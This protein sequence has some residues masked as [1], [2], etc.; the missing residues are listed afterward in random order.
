[1]TDFK[2]HNNGVNPGY[3]KASGHSEYE[4]LKSNYKMFIRSTAK[5]DF[6]NSKTY[7]EKQL[8][9][10]QEMKQQAF[11][12]NLGGEIEE[13][14][15]EE[16]E[17]LKKL[18]EIKPKP[19]P[20]V[21]IYYPPII[22]KKAH[23]E[24]A[25]I[26]EESTGMPEN[27]G[28]EAVETTQDFS[29]IN[30]DTEETAETPEINIQTG[31]ST[32]GTEKLQLSEAIKL[33]KNAGIS[34]NAAKIIKT[35]LLKSNEAGDEDTLSKK[36]INDIIELK[37]T[38]TL[39]GMVEQSEKNHQLNNTEKNGSKIK[40]SNSSGDFVLQNGTVIE[41]NNEESYKDII[42]QYHEMVSEKEDNLLCDVVNK[43]SSGGEIN[44][45][46]MRVIRA[47]RTSGIKCDNLM[48]LTD[49]CLDENS[50]I[51]SENLRAITE[52]KKSGALSKDIGIMLKSCLGEDGK[53]DEAKLRDACE[54]TRGVING[55]NIAD[56][57]NKV[58]DDQDTKDFFY[59]LSGFF[60]HTADMSEVLKTITDE[61]GNID[62][63][64]KEI[65]Y[66]AAQN[67]AEGSKKTKF[68]TFNKQIKEIIESSKNH[69]EK[70]SN[71]IGWS[72]CK[73]MSDHQKNAEEI[74]SA[75]EACRNENGKIDEDLSDILWNLISLGLDTATTLKYIDSCK[76][77]D[78]RINK[79]AAE[80]LIEM[81]EI[82]QTIEEKTEL[83][84]DLLMPGML[85][86]S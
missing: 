24:S 21:Q 72:I 7:I 52:L 74:I 15:K 1:M 23:E 76:D 75:L 61:D 18:S 47:L 86:N 42:N 71:E 63:Y 16:S 60:D 39:T 55:K 62:E 54:M 5:S 77:A 10:L 44:H 68:N 40:F 8:E 79:N 48:E 13:L 53:A 49:L 73:I 29:E 19:E 17:L 50:K 46:A 4:V 11:I 9:M 34:S 3:E 30:T 69:G 57:L 22:V 43:Y 41:L 80:V 85:D 25:P 82:P 51:N 26:S 81:T 58:G 6:V 33:M 27:S 2:V 12:E 28:A 14:V 78:G 66:S 59:D 37:L 20:P 65:V 35:E 38:L 70:Q 36:A 56:I 64:A 67:N 45:N 31:E 32:Q 83:V 84:H